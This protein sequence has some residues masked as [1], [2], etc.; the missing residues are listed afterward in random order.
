VLRRLFGPLQAQP[1]PP[2]FTVR[3]RGG[4]LLAWQD[5]FRSACQQR[6]GVAATDALEVPAAPVKSQAEVV[7]DPAAAATASIP[8]AQVTTASAKPSAGTEKRPATGQSRRS[9]AATL[10]SIDASTKAPGSHQDSP[11]TQR[12]VA[13]PPAI[14]RHPR[15]HVSGSAKNRVPRPTGA[16]EAPSAPAERK[17]V[18]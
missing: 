15:A 1:S 18:D 16:A 7:S 3:L 4:Q 13:P 9:H 11:S 2:G 10:K 6:Y 8:L 17:P 12:G 5:A 14:H